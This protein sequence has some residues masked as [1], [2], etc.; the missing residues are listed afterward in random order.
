MLQRIRFTKKGMEVETQEGDKIVEKFTVSWDALKKVMTLEVLEYLRLAWNPWNK[1]KL[2]HP[3][4]VFEFP[5][6]A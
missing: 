5:E 2:H 4:S 1:G 3:T 6:S